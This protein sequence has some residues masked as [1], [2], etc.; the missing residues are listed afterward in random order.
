MRLTIFVISVYKKPK[1]KKFLII[2]VLLAL[3]F[4]LFPVFPFFHGARSLALGYSTLA[5]NYDVNALF[6]NPALL[7]SQS[8]SLA[9]YQYGRS[10]LDFRDLSGDL[11]AAR[12]FDLEHFQSLGE[13]D[14]EA[15]LSALRRAFSA[16]VPVHGFRAHGP[17]YAGKGYAVSVAYV[18]AA[19]V[20]PLA[21]ESSAF[22]DRPA[23]AVTDADVAALRVRFTGLQYTD[24]ALAVGFPMGQGTNVGATIHYLHGKRRMLDAGLGD[25]AI[26]SRADAGDLLQAAWSGLEDKFS[27]FTFDLG[28]V[29]DL[30]PHFR[31]GLAVRNAGAPAIAEGLRLARRYVAGLAFRPD[32]TMAICL[33]VDLGK[34]ELVPGGL[35]AQPFALGLEKG[36]FRNK[37][38]LRAGMYSDLAAAYF[39]GRRS[40]ALY[41]LGAG[42]N[43]GKFLID[44]A[45]AFDS[46][47]KLKNL[48]FSG[49]YALK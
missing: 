24:Y 25:G 42:F 17:G 8:A 4:P 22:L 15:A 18:D 49:F 45:L 39:V 7:G 37:L 32:A 1:M 23:S 35:E 16:D 3:A 12:A 38:L 31:A 27:K 28:A 47:G 44:L 6:L 29:A 41:G 9:G 36:L 30:G 10:T 26:T 14:R 46:H 2:A 5:F 40:N 20:S 43:L 11:A 21:G 19:V 48:G 33:D 13:A 34:S